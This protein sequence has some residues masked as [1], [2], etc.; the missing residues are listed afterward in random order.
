MVHPRIISAVLKRGYGHP[1]LQGIWTNNTVTPFERPKQLAEREFLTDD[2]VSVLEQRAARLF[3]GSGDL[4]VGDEL[5]LS[6]LANPEGVH[7]TTRPVGDYNQFWVDDG[8]VFESRR[9]YW[10]RSK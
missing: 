7:R 9:R 6:L 2:E 1:D 10:R 5:F 8:L 4:A 3:D